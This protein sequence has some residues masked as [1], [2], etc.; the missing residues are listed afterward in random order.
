MTDTTVCILTGEALKGCFSFHHQL[1][2]LLMTPFLLFIFTPWLLV[3][4]L[5]GRWNA[6]TT[7]VVNHIR[8]GLIDVYSSLLVS[9]LVEKRLPVAMKLQ[10]EIVTQ[11][12]TLEKIRKLKVKGENLS[13]GN[14]FI[15]TLFNSPFLS[16]LIHV[17][18]IHVYWTALVMKGKVTHKRVTTAFSILYTIFHFSIREVGM[19]KVSP[20]PHNCESWRAS[21]LPHLTSY[22]NYLWVV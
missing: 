5:M 1:I 12:Y 13:V 3:H 14:Y 7:L 2:K 17:H 20:L 4:H 22:V 16:L 10:W 15:C 21:S 8:A 6:I 11:T 19:R 9:P 18:I